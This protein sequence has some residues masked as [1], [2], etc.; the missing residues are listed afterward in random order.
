[1]DQFH[2]IIEDEFYYFINFSWIPLSLGDGFLQKDQTMNHT[3]MDIDFKSRFTRVND[4]MP[5]PLHPSEGPGAGLN[6]ET[7]VMN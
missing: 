2:L 1:M 5:F 3:V 7:S 6:G 4:G